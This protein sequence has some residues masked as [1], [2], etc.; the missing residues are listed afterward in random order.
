M[1][2]CFLARLPR[3][4]GCPQPGWRSVGSQGLAHQPTPS[5]S[6]CVAVGADARVGLRTSGG[7]SVS[8]RESALVLGQVIVVVLVSAIRC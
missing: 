1:W 3:T 7:G 2:E 8:V 4:L 5:G 6:V